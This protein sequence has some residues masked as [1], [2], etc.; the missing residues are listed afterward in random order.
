[1]ANMLLYYIH[2]K[3][4]TAA[5]GEQYRRFFPHCDVVGL[6][7]RAETPW[8]ARAEFAAAFA[9]LA[10]RYE[11]IFLIANSIGAYFAMH[12]LPQEK[13]Q[14]A[15][16]LSPIVDMERLILD[17]M[18]QAQVS[19][20]DLRKKGT[21]ETA[22]GETLSWA[23]LSYVRA[24]PLDWRVPTDI[25]YGGRDNLTTR[26]M[27]SAFAAAHPATLTILEEG[28]HWFHTEEQL[29]FLADWMQKKAGEQG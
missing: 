6:D 8:E 1:M 24:H 18:R 19:E 5:E 12:A 28:E 20:A 9:P 4:G 25:L 23:Y 10:A 17:M 11:T 27:I 15:Y 13:L 14:K 2:G 26:E 22:S 21:I 16:F 3:G 29:A 7:Y